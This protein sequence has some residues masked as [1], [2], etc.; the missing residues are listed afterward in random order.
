MV[1]QRKNISVIRATISPYEFE[2][3][4]ECIAEIVQKYLQQYGPEAM[5][6]WEP[7]YYRSG[8]T[9]PS[10]CFVI[11][12]F[13]EE[14]DEEFAARF[15]KEETLRKMKEQQDWETYQRLA[16]RFRDREGFK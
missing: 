8:G 15:E 5:V 2:G 3:K 11:R 10:P 1:Q 13:R 12:T 14:T 4:F 6:Y 16:E 9:D 7:E